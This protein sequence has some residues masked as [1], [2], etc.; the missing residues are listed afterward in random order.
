[1]LAAW[2]NLS[3]RGAKC[4]EQQRDLKILQFNLYIVDSKRKEEVYLSEC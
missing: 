1:M 4:V 3:P 2:V